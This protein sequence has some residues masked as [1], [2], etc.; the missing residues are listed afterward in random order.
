MNTGLT[1]IAGILVLG[2]LVLIHE[3]G[4]FLFAKLFKVKVLAFSIGFGKPILKKKYGETEYRISMIPFG[5]YVHMAGEHPEDTKEQKPWEFNQKPIWQR[6][7]IAMAG[8][9]F[10]LISA[11]AFLWLTFIVGMKQPLFLEEPI[12]GYIQEGSAAQQ[13]GI[14]YGDRILSIDGTPVSNWEEI[15]TPFTKLKPEYT[16]TIDRHGEKHIFTVNGPD[17]KSGEKIES[18]TAGMG[19]AMP[20]V[21]GT[22]SEGFPAENA[23]IQPGDSIISFN[24]KEIYSWAEFSDAVASYDSTQKDVPLTVIRNNKEMSFSLRPQFTPQEARYLVGI[25]PAEPPSRTVRSGVFSAI[26][27]AI[28]KTVDMIFQTFDMLEKLVT[29]E[30]STKHLAGP[31]GIIGESGKSV[32]RGFSEMLMFTAFISINLALLNLLPFF[33]ITDGGLIF[34]MLIEAVRGR[35]LSLKVQMIINQVAIAFM[36]VLALYVTK[37]DIVRLIFQ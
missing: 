23:G 22:L 17:L 9:S 10:N 33:I 32:F 18:I 29:L 1:Y 15:M 27:K 7:I 26:P 28:D 5:G 14:E 21:V 16:I 6:A 4:H 35:P 2:V 3:L 36:I 19:A 11:I 13:A 31:V 20:A 30:V 8:P 25:A 37:N 34:F 12:V 24:N